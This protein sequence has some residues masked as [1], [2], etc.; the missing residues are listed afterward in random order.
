MCLIFFP[1][2]GLMVG[3]GMRL[4]IKVVRPQPQ[5]QFL[6]EHWVFEIQAM[7]LRPGNYLKEL[8]LVKELVLRLAHLRLEG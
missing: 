1:A 4:S 7:G 6:L 3:V 8:V 5:L 2:S